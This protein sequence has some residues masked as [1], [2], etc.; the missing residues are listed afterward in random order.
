MCRKPNRANQGG[1][2]HLQI[3]ALE[4]ILQKEKADAKARNG[5]QKLTIERLRQQIVELQV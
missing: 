4:A 1:K 5:R 3:E 2:F